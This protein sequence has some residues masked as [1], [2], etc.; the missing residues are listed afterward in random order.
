MFTSKSTLVSRCGRDKV[1]ILWDLNKYLKLRTIPTY[2][3]TEAL[4][5]VLL[6]KPFPHLKV[7]DTG[8]PHVIT[9]GERGN[10]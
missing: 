1:L 4:V 8:S 10:S 3:C 6:G 9:A 5:P 7:S 2:E